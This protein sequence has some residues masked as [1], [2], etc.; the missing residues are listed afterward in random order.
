MTH[1]PT[2]TNPPIVVRGK[3]TAGDPT[4]SKPNQ[5]LEMRALP[6]GAEAY[7]GAKE[8]LAEGAVWETDAGM[9]SGQGPTEERGEGVRNLLPRL[10]T[11]D[12]RSQSHPPRDGPRGLTKGG[13]RLQSETGW[14]P[15][16]EFNIRGLPS[17]KTLR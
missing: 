17:A 4:L 10:R 11:R 16:E 13:I 15:G 14:R 5:V 3:A 12:G 9:C 1:P 8:P 6:P 2:P 7:R